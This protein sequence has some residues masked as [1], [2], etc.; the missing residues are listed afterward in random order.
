M[1]KP[2]KHD[3]KAER[4]RRKLREAQERARAGADERI[5]ACLRIAFSFG[6]HANATD[7][8][9]LRRHMLA[10]RPQLFVQ[11]TADLLEGRRHDSIRSMN[12]SLSSW[13]RDGDAWQREL[14]RL[15]GA[16]RG[17]IDPE[18]TVE[19]RRLLVE[20]PGL[21]W[22]AVEGYTD[23]ELRRFEQTVHR[24]HDAATD[25]ETA[26]IMRGH[27]EQAARL[28]GARVEGF[29]RGFV[30]HRNERIVSRFLGAPSEIRVLLPHIAWTEE[31]RV[32]ARFGAAHLPVVERL[33]AAGLA[34][35]V[36]DTPALGF[37]DEVFIRLAREPD[38]RIRLEEAVRCL[39]WDMYDA[40]VGGIYDGSWTKLCTARRKAFE[41]LGGAKGFLDL[42]DAT[43]RSCGNAAAL[44]HEIR[45]RLRA[46]TEA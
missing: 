13:R 3:R 30:A 2:T 44:A 31:V 5:A 8:A 11:E 1:S 27:I 46:A 41:R 45:A 35:A 24:T 23:D 9:E 6:R 38:G 36:L 42:L 29:A 32:L 22:F 26:L 17:Q 16:T 43:R 25:D 14:A 37:P 10:V 18:F 34:A 20:T 12:A 15:R 21:A 4:R 19:E 40:L 39:Y 28:H 33:N 7:A